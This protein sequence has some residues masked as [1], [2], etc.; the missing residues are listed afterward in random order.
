LE[1]D[2][3]KSKLCIA[4]LWILVFLLGGV[5]GG[6]SHYLYREHV[7][8]KPGDFVAKLARDLKLDAQQTTSLKAIFD[9]SFQRHQALKQECE[10]RFKAIRNETGE[11]IKSILRPDQKLLFEEKLKKFRKPGPP[12]SPPPPPPSQQGR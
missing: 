7:K 11:K 10:S 5:A 4:L 1:F 12:S 9:E 8:P 3:M 6:I 2:E